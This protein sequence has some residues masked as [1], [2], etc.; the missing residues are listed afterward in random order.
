MVFISEGP[1]LNLWFGLG[2]GNVA[3]VLAYPPY[4]FW[5][6]SFSSY[7]SM[8]RFQCKVFM[9]LTSFSHFCSTFSSVPYFGTISV[10]NHI[11]R[12]EIYWSIRGKRQKRG[13]LRTDTPT[14]IVSRCSSFLGKPSSSSSSM[15]GTKL[16]ENNS[17]NFCI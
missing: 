16:R 2:L 8:P 14:Y 9:G 10:P 11:Y 4:R 15:K 12:N 1:V 7:F 5:Y 3:S 6:P 13:F 17:Q